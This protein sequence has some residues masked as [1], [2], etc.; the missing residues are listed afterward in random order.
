M[1]SES[2]IK[3]VAPIGVAL[4]IFGALIYELWTRLVES[5]GFPGL[6]IETRS[7]RLLWEMAT[8]GEGS[9]AF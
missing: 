3:R 4:F 2:E 5:C 1:H 8:M 6:K 9:V 7:T